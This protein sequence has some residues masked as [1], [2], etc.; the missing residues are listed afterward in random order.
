MVAALCSIARTIRTTG[1][2]TLAL[3]SAVTGLQANTN[4]TLPL[5]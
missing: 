1:A 2:E 4:Q 3:M 5:C